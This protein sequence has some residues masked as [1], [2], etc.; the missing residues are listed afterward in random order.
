M[1][2]V[3]LHH[4]TLPLTSILLNLLQRL[5]ATSCSQ[6]QQALSILEGQPYFWTCKH[7]K[8]TNPAC[9]Q[10]NFHCIFVERPHQSSLLYQS[11]HTVHQISLEGDCGTSFWHA[12][13]TSTRPVP[14]CTNRLAIFRRHF[15]SRKKSAK[16]RQ[17]QVPAR[18]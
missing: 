15:D 6:Y 12:V 7:S 14:T 1:N 8:L 17:C 10:C 13:F 2:V 3:Q 9:V 16:T 18:Y 5:G 11:L 4:E